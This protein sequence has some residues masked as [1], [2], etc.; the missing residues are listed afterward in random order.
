MKTNENRNGDDRE[1][2]WFPEMLAL[3]KNFKKETLSV[4]FPEIGEL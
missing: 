1:I 4:V 3:D 2:I